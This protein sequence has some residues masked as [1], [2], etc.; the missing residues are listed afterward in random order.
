M[1]LPGRV[2]MPPPSRREKFVMPPNDAS[3]FVA[4][5]FETAKITAF[6]GMRAPVK[7]PHQYDNRK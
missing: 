2:E 3:R 4:F 5:N 7:A 6:T 1:P